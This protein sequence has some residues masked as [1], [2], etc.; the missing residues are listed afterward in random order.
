M[1]LSKKFWEYHDLLFGSQ[2]KLSEALYD[3]LAKNLKLDLTA[4][5]TCRNNKSGLMEMKDDL[6]AGFRAGVRGTPTWF[7]NG[8]KIEGVIS[9]NDWQKIIQA[10]IKERFSK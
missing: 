2:E 1:L 10:A 6:E 4:F 3:E 8:R 5:E 7:V 9:K